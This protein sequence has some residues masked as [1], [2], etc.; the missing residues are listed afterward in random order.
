MSR[1]VY[2]IGIN[3]Y[4]DK[5]SIDGKQIYQYQLWKDMLRRCYSESYQLA[6][7]SYINCSVEDHFHSFTNFNDFIMEMKGYGNLNWHLDKDIL[8]KGN[9]IY[10]RETICFIPYQINSFMT[11]S[12]RIRG[13][14]PIGVTYCERKNRFR[15]EIYIDGK[16][17]KLGSFKNAEDAFKIYKIAKEKQFKILAERWKKEIDKRVYKSLMD[18]KVEITD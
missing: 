3:D 9:K 16:C 10:S 1:L 11:K 6:Y 2:G 8:I 17:K 5:V 18:Y 12:N 4:H 15:S 13:K 14:Y 7:P